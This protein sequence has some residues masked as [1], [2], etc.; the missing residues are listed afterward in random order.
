M[1]IACPHALGLAVPLVIAVSTALAAKSGFLIRDRSASE[2]A[3]DLT[4]VVFDKTGTLTEG[5]F[6]VTDVLAF[7][8]AAQEDVVR[9]TASV[10]AHSE[11]P[12]ARGGGPKCGRTGHFPAP[13]RRIPRDPGSRRRREGRRQ[14]RPGGRSGLPRRAGDCG[15][16]RAGRDAPATGEDRRLPAARGRP[17]GRRDRARR[18]HPAGV[19]RSR[20]PA[21]SD[22][23]TVH[24]AD[25]RQ[26]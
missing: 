5:R 10:E 20:P 12:I 25:R 17:T 24:D 22:G 9:T 13:A 7:G 3:K 11:H 26:P 19:G 16:G 4:A 14:D 23:C 6:G 2:R 18:Y 15:R 1:V 8:G 21:Q